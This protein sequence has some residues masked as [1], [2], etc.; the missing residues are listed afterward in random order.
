MKNKKIIIA[1]GTGFIGQEM[2]KYF[3]KENSIVILTR[4]LPDARN[5]RNAYDSLTEK[6]LQHVRYIKWDGKT[7]DAWSKALDNADLL[8][9]LAGKTVNC[10][11]TEKNKKEILDSRVNAV[12]VLGEAIR[13]CTVAPAVWINASSATIYRHAMDHAQDE[14]STEFHD[15]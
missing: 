14:Y 10:R 12:K 8:I 1:G 13:Q 2:I 7:L 4:Q 11:Y 3:G 9:N 6:D 5:N 15:G